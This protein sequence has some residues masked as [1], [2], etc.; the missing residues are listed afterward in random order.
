M[1][2]Q[3]KGDAVVYSGA[4]LSTA[5]GIKD[6]ASTAVNSIVRKTYGTGEAA[7]SRLSLKPS[8][9]HQ[10]VAALHKKKLVSHWVNQSHDRLAQKAGFP[11][12]RLLEIHGAWGD[13][14]NPVASWDDKLRYD[15]LEWL[16]ELVESEPK[17]CLVLGSSLCGMNADQ[18]MHASKD[19]VIIGTGPT[20]Y[21]EEC[22]VRIW[23]LLDD[24]LRRLYSEHVCAGESGAANK[25]LPNSECA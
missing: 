8:L 13:H 11:Q 15:L 17:V 1:L 21:D 23:G 4:G 24:V 7:G 12:D 22:S 3:A 14:K 18:I 6:Y 5:S 10:A 25:K 2:R 19:V 20:P 16:W 9:G